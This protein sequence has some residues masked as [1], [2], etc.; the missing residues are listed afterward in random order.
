MI[1]QASQLQI[2]SESF[3]EIV[4]VSKQGKQDIHNLFP[5]IKTLDT[6]LSFFERK[7]DK[8]LKKLIRFFAPT[9]KRKQTSEIVNISGVLINEG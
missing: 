6:E 5:K 7:K 3:D 2:I 4:I 9:T 1:K 8:R